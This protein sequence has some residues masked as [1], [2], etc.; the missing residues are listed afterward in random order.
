MLKKSSRSLSREHS[1]RVCIAIAISSALIL[2]LVQCATPGPSRLLTDKERAVAIMP[3][4]QDVSQQLNEKCKSAGKVETFNHMDNAK[5]RAVE[6]DAN[7]V[8]NI[9]STNRNGLLSHDVRFWRCKKG[10]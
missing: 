7:I 4:S 9:Y 2:S 10:F 8:Q 1:L 5:I 6:L 3:A